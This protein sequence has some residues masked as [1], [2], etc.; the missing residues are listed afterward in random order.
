MINE[1][2]NK[3]SLNEDSVDILMKDVDFDDD[4]FEGNLQV[5]FSCFIL[6]TTLATSW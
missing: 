1:N 4:D 2:D 6:I 3:L 5:T